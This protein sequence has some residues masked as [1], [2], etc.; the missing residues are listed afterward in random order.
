MH[1]VRMRLP[2]GGALAAALTPFFILTCVTT[3][4]CGVT[5]TP[6]SSAVCHAR[7]PAPIDP[8]DHVQSRLYIHTLLQTAPS[9]TQ[10][11][12][13]CNFPNL[14][15]CLSF[16]T[17]STRRMTRDV[18]HAAG[19]P[20]L[21]MHVSDCLPANTYHARLLLNSNARARRA[22]TTQPRRSSDF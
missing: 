9:G 1:I 14:D 20:A 4:V 10:K 19:I 12:K 2:A 6:R 11:H 21:A 5:W 7:L 3:A 13:H 16:H 22:T 18:P 8:A 17:A 15:A